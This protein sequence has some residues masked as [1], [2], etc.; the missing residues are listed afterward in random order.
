MTTYINTETLEYPI[1][2]GDIRAAFRHSTSFPATGFVPPPGY[3]AVDE[4]DP[5]EPTL[6]QSVR[7]LP[8]HLVEGVWTQRWE[9]TQAPPELVA[10]RRQALVESIDNACA[11]IYTRV[12]RFSEEYKE[13]EAQAIAFKAAGYTGETPRAVAAFSIPAGVSATYATDAILS[14]AALLRE[15]LA[16]LGELR[17]KKYLIKNLPFDQAVDQF[18]DVIQAITTVGKSL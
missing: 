10:E 14:Q 16:K 18:N 11:T 1:Y 2:E 3:A 4:V 13:R 5:P 7:E 8:P 17:M 12:G 15:A 6:E 9:V